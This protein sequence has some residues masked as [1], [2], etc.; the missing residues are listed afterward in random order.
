[1]QGR[2]IAGKSGPADGDTLRGRARRDEP[3]PRSSAR[4]ER[5]RRARAPFVQ[6][7]CLSA[8]IPRMGWSQS[9]SLSRNSPEAH[10]AIFFLALGLPHAAGAVWFRVKTIQVRPVQGS[11]GSSLP[12][13][14]PNE[15]ARG[16]RARDG[17]GA[18]NA[19]RSVDSGFWGRV[20]R[21]SSGTTNP[22]AR[23]P[24]DKGGAPARGTAGSGFNPQF[25]TGSS[26]L[27]GP[28]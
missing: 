25:S 22:P 2:R 12:L 1:M 21:G 17:D 10:T 4:V 7:Q 14:S 15:L 24:S 28:P 19:R 8:T 26:E 27:D 11:R 18:R 20:Q 23:S 16:L 13:A 3:R 9:S 6:H 5:A